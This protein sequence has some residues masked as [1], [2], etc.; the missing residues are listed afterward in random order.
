MEIYC[1]D[2]EKSY[3]VTAENLAQAKPDHN[4]RPTVCP[5]CQSRGIGI[6]YALRDNQDV[7]AFLKGELKPLGNKFFA[8]KAV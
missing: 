6:I 2:C 8:S 1:S 5:K 7:V 4:G 3:L